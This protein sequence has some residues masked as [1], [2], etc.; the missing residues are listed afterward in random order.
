[1]LN[2]VVHKEFDIKRRFGVEL[3][4][5]DEIK[6]KAVQTAIVQISPHKVFISRYALTSNNDYWH[7]KDDATCG[8][9]GRSGP[10]GVEVASYVGSGFD[11]LQ[12]I[13]EIAF[14]LSNLGCKTNDNCGL[15]IHADVCDLNV[16]QISV[17]VAHWIKLEFVLSM[18][19]PIRRMQNE[20]CKF[21]FP[22]FLNEMKK[23][24]FL[25][26]RNMKYD[27]IDF[28]HKITPS[29]LGIFDN[30]DRRFNLNLVNFARAIQNGN[31]VRK[32]LELRW[33]EGTLVSNDISN[34]VMLFL[35]L[36]EVCKDKRMPKD[37]SPY[38]LQQVFDLLGVK[39]KKNK[40]MI[41]GKNLHT[42][43]TW[44][45]ERIV[46][47]SFDSSAFYASGKTIGFQ[48]NTLRDAN[49]FLNIM[50]HPVKISY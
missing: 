6:K 20:Y 30:N 1:M 36:I 4:M 50:W 14:H 9:G 45:C 22:P 5:G 8:R 47:N 23:N 10:K 18:L 21:V 48:Q 25:I 44:L 39:H 32:T 12:H 2:S 29:N 33:P 41:L 49:K 13:G 17:I 24:D 19:L 37:L 38:S 46:K 40:F 7:V 34:W 16:K 43:K 15:H 3:E 31:Q 35:C 42:I 27:A 11:D 26:H 28:W